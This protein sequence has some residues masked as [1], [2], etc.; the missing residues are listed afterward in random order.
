MLIWRKAM[1]YLFRLLLA[2]LVLLTTAAPAATP[3][4][5]QGPVPPAVTLFPVAAGLSQ[6][7][8]VT[9]AGDGSG[10]VFIV[11]RA[12][13]IRI[14]KNGVLQATAFLDIDPRVNSSGSEEGLLSVAFAPSFE[15]NGRFY[16]Y[17]NNAAGDL[18]IS[19]FRVTGTNPD[20]ADSTTEQVI[21]TVPHPGQGN[22]NGGQLQFGPDGMLY[23][24]T[25][26]GGGGGDPDDNAQDLDSWLGKFLR[27]NVENGS[28]VTYTIP[29]G[30]PFAGATAGRDE[31]WAYGLRNP[32]RFS[33]DRGTGD[34]WSGDVGQGDRE[35]INRQ[36][37]GQAGLN[38]GWDCREGTIQ[39]PGSRSPVCPTAT[40]FTEPVF[41]Y[42]RT[43]GNSVTGGYVYRGSRIP[44][45]VGAYVF[46]DF[47]S[48]QVWA[49]Y[50][51][52]NPPA[53]YFDAGFLVSSFGENE[54]GDLYIV[55]YTGSV[56]LFVDSSQ[57]RRVFVPA[58]LK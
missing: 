12:G 9:H 16:V 26:D 19:R 47:G 32:W 11:E 39:H 35:E 58:V 38:Y 28:P 2:L 18:V 3:V 13:R 21:I 54:A 17:Y 40:G 24:G 31:I 41:D 45:L 55:D 25:G 8:F 30:N 46:A 44:G 23:I 27:L 10:R 14:L 15:T 56:H 50:P 36:P 20:V 57:V 5:A 6:P 53:E 52:S 4:L 48:G 29:A 43:S 7:V 49:L 42:G 37:A 33:F 1:P 51:G 22:H 34:L